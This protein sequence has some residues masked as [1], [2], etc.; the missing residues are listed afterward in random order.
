MNDKETNKAPDIYIYSDI[1]GKSVNKDYAGEFL[2]KNCGTIIVCDGLG[3]EGDG[4]LASKFV[5]E[6]MIKMF[7]K[8]FPDD[9]TRIEES[10]K[11]VNEQLILY[12]KKQ[13]L[14]M[15]TT[16]VG[17]VFK[18][19]RLIYFNIGDSRLYYF[20]EDKL[21]RQSYDHSAARLAVELKEITEEQIRTH[22]HRNMLLKAI[23]SDE[24]LDVKQLYGEVKIEEGD[25]CLLC[26]DGFWEYVL[27]TEMEDALEKTKTA[28]EW[29]EPMKEILLG[30][31]DEN[32]DNYTVAC[33]RFI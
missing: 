1:G 22:K 11:E 28:E 13:D 12:Q 24:N 21:K 4:D 30:R 16:V 14:N 6:Y 10:L 29:A 3:G 19:D 32:N 8:S 33:A 26:T 31:I 25:A 20:K 15:M 9:Q 5:C 27:E 7:K 23:G 17:C 2:G 18:D